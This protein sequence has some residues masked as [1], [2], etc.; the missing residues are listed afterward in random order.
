MP[1]VQRLEALDIVELAQQS[2]ELAG[3]LDPLDAPH[4]LLE[5]AL[6]AAGTRVREVPENGAAQAPALADEQQLLVR[7]PEAV[8]A[9]T[10]GQL[11][12]ESLR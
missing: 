1:V 4:V 6:A 2:A 10:F 8:D 5:V 9:G 7:P 12:R 11:L 3:G